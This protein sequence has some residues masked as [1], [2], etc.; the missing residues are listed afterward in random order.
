MFCY[1][2]NNIHNNLGMI[3]TMM[4]MSFHNQYIHGYS[5][6]PISPLLLL[7]VIASPRVPLKFVSKHY[8]NI[9]VQISTYRCLAWL[10]VISHLTTRRWWQT[11]RRGHLNITIL[12][13]AI[14]VAT[15]LLECYRTVLYSYDNIMSYGTQ[16][17][18]CRCI[19]QVVVRATTAWS[20]DANKVTHS[21][22]LISIMMKVCLAV[23]KQ[24]KIIEYW[25]LMIRK[26]IN[27]I[28]IIMHMEVYV[29]FF[30]KSCYCRKC[31]NIYYYC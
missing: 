28:V 20:C 5:P 19:T 21:K 17:C 10:P 6:P 16:G 9:T 7:A 18:S 15:L 27:R 1:L 31:A 24:W 11:P 12:K 13:G 22:K 25:R 29:F 14:W 8:N 30:P 2:S 26:I 3:M 4:K 23:F